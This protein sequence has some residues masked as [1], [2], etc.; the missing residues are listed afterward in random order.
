MQLRV[1]R[2]W[3]QQCRCSL[4]IGNVRPYLFD[5]MLCGP[6]CLH[7]FS[8]EK[9]CV[10]ITCLLNTHVLQNSI[11]W[12]LLHSTD[13]N[14]NFKAFWRFILKF[15]VTRKVLKWRFYRFAYQFLAKSLFTTLK[16]FFK[17][18]YLP[19]FKIFLPMQHK[20][21][22]VWPKVKSCPIVSSVCSLK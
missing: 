22:Y 20:I 9:S 21:K 18:T 1:M 11:C 13:T 17:P 3:Y 4:L 7:F 6:D 14:G 10:Q 16:L 15:N 19:R 12:T 2:T 8:N 5:L